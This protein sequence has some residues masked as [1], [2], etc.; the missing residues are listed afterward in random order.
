M[1]QKKAVTLIIFIALI[2]TT[3]QLSLFLRTPKHF[4]YGGFSS[5][6]YQLQNIDPNEIVSSGFELVVMDYSRD[7]TNETAFSRSDIQMIKDAGVVPIAYISIGEAEDYR[8]Y[9]NKTWSTD[10]PVWL[11]KENPEWPG[12]YPVKFWYL[13][14]KKIVFKY[15]DIIISQGFAGL[16]LDKVDVFEYWSDPD[17]GEN[18][19][20]DE[21]QVAELMIN[22]V[23]EIAEYCRVNRSMPDFLI[24]PQN[25]ERI[26]EY[27]E[28]EEYLDAISGIG[29]E[30]L[31]YIETESIPTNATLERIHYIDIVAKANK[32]VLSVD[33]VDDGTGYVGE[34]KARIDDYINKA[35]EKG[36]IPYAAKA[37]RA[38]D[39]LNIIPGVQPPR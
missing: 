27:D 37:D 2:A 7:G 29:I 9:W 23:V 24:I 32:L 35:R 30:D 17:N 15:V 21:E 25:G 12:N 5:W 36:Y 31:W 33:Y 39:E 20:M 11:G 28:D 4:E 13:E 26:L 14:W 22:F 6:G 16:Y 3:V 34:N 10:P 19:T 38:L 1:E 18:F 8:F